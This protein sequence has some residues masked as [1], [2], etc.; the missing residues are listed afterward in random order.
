MSNVL[1]NLPGNAIIK[2][3]IGDRALYFCM[4]TTAA[5]VKEDIARLCAQHAAEWLDLHAK[6]IVRSPRTAASYWLHEETTV[7]FPDFPGLT[8][9]LEGVPTPGVPWDV[10]TGDW[11]V[12]RVT[13]EEEEGQD[14]SC[15]A[16]PS[17][18]LPKAADFF[19]R[20]SNMLT[21]MTGSGTP[22]P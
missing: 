9:Y 20:M 3:A 16:H 14:F 19:R 11:C 8:L 13:F 17:D 6:G 2:G 21:A 1:D 4:E 10:R 18:A 12:C 15:W 22:T 7:T 5:T